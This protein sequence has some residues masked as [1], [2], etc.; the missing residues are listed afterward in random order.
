MMMGQGS[1]MG[2]TIV[3][4]DATTLDLLLEKVYRDGRHDFRGYKRGTVTRRLERRL[5]ATGLKT[6]LEYMQFLDAY[7]EEYERLAD[8]L[9]IKVSGF[10]RSSYTFQQVAKLVLSELTLFKRDRGERELRL[11][12]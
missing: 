12:S 3:E 6:Y 8:D 2:N 1:Y 5:H 9:T 4:N 7:P 10:F 11:W